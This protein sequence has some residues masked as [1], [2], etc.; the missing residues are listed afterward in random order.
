VSLPNRK[1]SFIDPNEL[2][3]D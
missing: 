2:I 3:P 1:G